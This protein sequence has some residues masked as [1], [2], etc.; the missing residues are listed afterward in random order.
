MLVALA[1]LYPHAFAD[2]N[3][4]AR[5]NARLDNIDRAL[6]GGNSV[7]PAQAIAIEARGRI[8]SQGTFA[9]EVGPRRPEWS[10]LA[11]AGSL[12]NYLRYFLLP[13]RIAPGAPWILCFAC[14][15]A[16]F[17]GAQPVWEDSAEGLAILRRPP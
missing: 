17:P 5:A 7:L 6:G 9:V 11:D 12:E 14:D 16:A 3:R 1:W 8:P 15:R 13:R 10:V 2:A 4:S